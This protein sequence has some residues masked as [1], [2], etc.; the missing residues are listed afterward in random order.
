MQSS[1]TIP[2]I[3]ASEL[4]NTSTTSGYNLTFTLNTA[5]TS[6]NIL[7][8]DTTTGDT[9]KVPF[10]NLSQG[11]HTISVDSTMVPVGG[12][13]YRW[14]VQANSLSIVSASDTTPD[15]FTDET[16][17][18]LLNFYT[19]HGV[20]VDN[21]FNSDYFGRIYVAENYETNASHPRSYPGIYI[22]DAALT[23]VTGQGNVAYA[24]GVFAN[25]SSFNSPDRCVVAPGGLVYISDMGNMTAN[26][27]GVYVMDPANPGSAFIP[28]LNTATASPIG[29]AVTGSGD[30]TKLFTMDQAYTGATGGTAINNGL[31]YNIGTSTGIPGGT[32]D[33]IIYNNNTNGLI[34]TSLTT[35]GS[36][37][38]DN[39]TSDGR[40]G[41]FIGQ[42][43]SANATS[44]SQGAPSLF[45]VDSTGNVDANFGGQLLGSNP[46]GLAVSYD[47]SVL[48]ANIGGNDY[49]VFSVSYDASGVPSLTKIYEFTCPNGVSYSMAFD[50]AGNLYLITESSTLVGYSF[51]T[52]NNSFTTPAPSTQI[53]SI[54]S[55]PPPP[56]VPVITGLTLTAQ[57]A[58]L[59]GSIVNLVWTTASEQ[60][61]GANI[62]YT[63][64]RSTDNG[65]TWVTIGSQPAQNGNSTHLRT[66]NMTDSVTQNGVYEY[67]VVAANS[68]NSYSIT[69][70]TS[71]VSI[72]LPNP[73]VKVFPNPA[74]TVINVMLP[75]NTIGVI[76]YKLIAANGA[77]ALNGS[78]F[79]N[80]TGFVQIPVA[81]VASGVYFLQV[82]VNNI[83]WAKTYE[84]QIVH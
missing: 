9:T 45:H 32:P 30:N 72:L 39:I 78:A 15:K 75:A 16:T 47:G 58:Q 66:Y 63:V 82:V 53:L 38:F 3:Y 48:A 24:G 59:R 37:G 25:S 28:V 81:G 55:T 4:N 51:P 68:D 80:Q 13:N 52:P 21:D 73:N 69:S 11:V 64:Q 65:S 12:G 20:S 1:D 40:G 10:F 18:L 27:G 74:N 76:T 67:R 77:I 79:N 34:Y 57:L 54:S 17:N 26:N 46:P 41:F 29:L 19:A 44:D 23:D 5:A 42:T 71:S 49:K 14:A 35:S 36:G 50:R 60:N 83:N 61:A 56:P 70:N 2:H 8:I 6:G 43:R 84:V 62:T 31:Q 7:L 33:A 22:F